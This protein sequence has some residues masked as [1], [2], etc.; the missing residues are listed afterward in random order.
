MPKYAL[1]ISLLTI[2]LCPRIVWAEEACVYVDEIFDQATG[3][4]IDGE[5]LAQQYKKSGQVWYV[6]I[7]EILGPDE[8][9]KDLAWILFERQSEEHPEIYCELGRGRKVEPLQSLHETDFK[10]KF[11]MPG[12]GLPR[13]A[14]ADDPLEGVYVRSWA[15][16]ELGESLILSLA[17]QSAPSYTLL[18]SFDGANWIIL[19]KRQEKGTCYYDRGDVYEITRLSTR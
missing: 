17:Q 8:D 7:T 14:L 19:E 12:S 9:E 11:G 3:A 4:G 10:M 13:C 1:L 15:S 6:L 5:M 2:A 16:R 18:T